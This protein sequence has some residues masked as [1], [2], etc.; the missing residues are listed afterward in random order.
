M[1][2]AGVLFFI[3]WMLCGCCVDGM[4]DDGRICII[5]GAALIVAIGCALVLSRRGSIE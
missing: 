4:L 3:S 1:R 2:A 5:A